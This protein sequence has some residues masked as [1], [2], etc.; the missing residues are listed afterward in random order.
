MTREEKLLPCPFCG[1]EA[2]IRERYHTDEGYKI[3][4]G[5]TEC[6]CYLKVNL[7]FDFNKFIIEYEIEKMVKQWN[8]RVK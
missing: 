5:C 6:F 8:E 3:F 4:V 2:T 1:S 7:L